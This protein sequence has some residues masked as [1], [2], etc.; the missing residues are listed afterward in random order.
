MNATIRKHEG[1]RTERFKYIR[2]FEANPMLEQLFD[3]EE[4]PLETVNLVNSPKHSKT[5]QK[6]RDRTDELRDRYGGEFSTRLW[7]QAQ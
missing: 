5:L 3:L 2:F 6:L 1:V 4:D 7:K